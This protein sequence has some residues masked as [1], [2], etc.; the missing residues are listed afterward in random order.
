M[1]EYNVGNNANIS[2]LVY[3]EKTELR[4]LGKSKKFV[5]Q[6]NK[7]QPPLAALMNGYKH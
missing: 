3:F 1:S 2:N 6:I 7:H 5:A 4:N